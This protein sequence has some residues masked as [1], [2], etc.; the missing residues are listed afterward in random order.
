MDGS[1]TAAPDCMASHIYKTGVKDCTIKEI[2]TCL[3]YKKSLAD[4]YM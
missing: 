4:V 1:F 3:L 2:L